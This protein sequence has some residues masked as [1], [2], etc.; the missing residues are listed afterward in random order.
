MKQPRIII[1]SG[2]GQ[3][4]D[5]YVDAI[6]EY[7]GTPVIISP[8]QNN[9]VEE[10]IF[11]GLMLTG[12][13]DVSPSLYSERMSSSDDDMCFGT[14]LERDTV[15][16]NLIKKALS[17]NKPIL[18]ICRGMQ[19][20]NVYFGGTLIQ[21]VDLLHFENMYKFRNN[22]VGQG[23]FDAQK[24]KEIESDFHHI[25]ITL[26]SIFATILG[27]G[28]L[29]KV[30]S[31]HHQGISHKELASIFTASAYSIEDGI[32]EAYENKEHSILGVQFHPER[33]KEHPKQVMR[34]FE[35]FVFQCQSM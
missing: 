33:K 21:N 6:K 12:G 10:L 2:S 34:I 16:L 8:N 24:Y 3:D 32:I 13:G 35:N 29:L 19:L 9:I 14:S 17:D 4:V 11:D 28:G 20:L 27:S 30:N 15:E 25:F 26:G 23:N 18:G 5:N 22:T 1:S 7:N 31:R